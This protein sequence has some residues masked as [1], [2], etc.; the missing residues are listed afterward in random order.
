MNKNSGQNIKVSDEGTHLVIEHEANPWKVENLGQSH[1]DLQS[2]LAE[3][4]EI[5]MDP[6]RLVSVRLYF[7]LHPVRFLCL[8]HFLRC[9]SPLPQLVRVSLGLL[10]P[11]ERR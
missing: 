11:Q 7:L 4:S 6:L 3:L 2:P 8:P 9:K 5:H 1:E 10:Y